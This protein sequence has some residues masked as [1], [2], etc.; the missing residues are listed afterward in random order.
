[1]LRE[2]EDGAALSHLWLLAPVLLLAAVVGS[3][4]LIL[5]REDYS[6]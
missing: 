2:L 5:P 1:L 3:F 4:Q 6:L